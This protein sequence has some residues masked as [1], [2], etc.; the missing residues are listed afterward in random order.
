MAGSCSSSSSTHIYRYDVFISFRGEDTRKTFI[1]H[2]L[3]ALDGKKID[4]YIDYKLKSGDEI[5]PALLKAIEESKISLIVFSENY[6]SSRWC[7]DE[8]IHINECKER[9]QQ[10]VIPIFYRIDPSHVRYQRESYAAAFAK[11]EERFEDKRERVL[12]W[13]HAL[14]TIANLSGFDSL[15]TSN[16]S[17][18]VE[19]IVKAI[20]MQLDREL[21]TD[22]TGLVGVESRIQKIESLLCIDGIVPPEVC[23]RTVGIWGMGGIGKTTLAG[24]VFNRLSSQFEASCF[25]ANVREESKR[26]GLNHLRDELLRELLKEER[27]RIGTPSVGSTSVRKRLSHTKVLVVLDDVNDFSQLEH[28]VGEEVQ[29]GRGS[30]IIITTR[31]KQLLRDMRLLR[32]EAKNDVRIYEVQELNGNEALQLFHLNASTEMCSRGNF[33]FLRGL[34]DYASG[35]PLALKIWGSLF[36]RCKNMKERENFL[37]KLKT[38]PNEKLQNVYRV[39]YDVLEENEREIFLSIACFHKND[40]IHDAKR[41]LDACGLFADSGIEALIDMSLISIKSGLLWMHDVIQEMGWEIV[42]KECPEEPGKRSRLYT[43]NDVHHVLEKNTGT[44]KVQG[45]SVR[46]NSAEEQTW[47]QLTQALVKM[48]NLKFLNFYGYFSQYWNLQDLES[49]PNALRYLCWPE[50][51]LKS[52]PSKFSLDNLVELLMPHSQLQRLWNESQQILKNLRR[53][54]LS[55]SKQLVEVPDLSKSVN[56]KSIDLRGCTRLVE[57]PPYF[58]NL[59]KLTSLNLGHCSSLKICS[60]IPRNMKFL[61]LESTAIEELPS[62]IW[63]HK[64]LVQLNL[65]RCEG[66]KNLPNSI[67]KLNSLT[68]F[69]L[70]WTGIEGLPSSIECFSNSVVSIQ[71]YYCRRLV[72]L[73]TSICKLNCLSR[74]SLE[75]CSSFKNFPEILEPLESLKYL[76]LVG[77]DIKELPSS[78]Q[79]LVGL[80]TLTLS[81]CQS[82]ESVPNSIYYL[83]LL[84]FQVDG[85]CS[86]KA[87]PHSSIILWSLVHCLDF[88]GCNIFEEIPDCICSS[89]S[90]IELDLRDSMIKSIPSTIKQPSRL[91]VLNVSNCKRLESLPDLPCLRQLNASGCTK[92]KTVSF[93]M[94]ALTQGLDQV[95]ED[96][97]L[98]LDERHELYN[99]VN[100]D[101]NARS[102]IMDDA[103]LRIMHMATANYHKFQYE[104]SEF[105][106]VEPASVAVVCCGNEIP[107]WFSFQ[108]EGGSIQ[109]KLP[110]NWCDDA[111]FLGLAL[112][113]VV[114]INKPGMIDCGCNSIFKTINGDSHQFNHFFSIQVHSLLTSLGDVNSDHIFVWY[115]SLEKVR[116]TRLCNATIEAS[117]NFSAQNYVTTR[118][119]VCFLY[120]QALDQDAV[121]CQI[122]DQ[123]PTQTSPDDELV[124]SE[125]EISVSSLEMMFRKL[126]LY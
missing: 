109:I 66:L 57:V 46:L 64:N 123:V 10:S 28:L 92:L 30:R 108:R 15:T 2:L 55:D 87:L 34:V 95:C 119:G 118:C 23:L 3:K 41:Q 110:L 97:R 106:G 111:N 4:T 65:E 27:L 5:G 75:G 24:A 117:F 88:K 120:A 73:P 17:E 71:L 82:L 112:C 53:I 94:T 40:F 100:L 74:L 38:Y 79:N 67:W 113:A 58:Q 107:K 22:L 101:E 69:N 51:P 26:C 35:I 31:D 19:R 36:R 9:Y 56:I 98:Y 59:P 44:E 50:Y 43:P 122:I 33:I 62:S 60:E 68:S 14:T 86:L 42:R 49:L 84:N 103:H 52:L 8:M 70:C 80:K 16:D 21:S 32:K 54:D 96:A 105:W 99:C 125:S 11:H 1:S 93:S 115:D 76:N 45:I 7:L 104:G 116:S 63:S 77:T 47:T 72:S 83:S 102:N 12:K 114:T 48:Y 89:T 126:S 6:A 85:C 78:I 121:K 29:F 18:L 124:A 37:V 39:S 13:R 25:L 61:V 81:R 90:L 91:R 20:L